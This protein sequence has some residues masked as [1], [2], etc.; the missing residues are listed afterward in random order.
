[1]PL[2]GFCPRIGHGPIPL[3]DLSG[4]G[5][6]VRLIGRNRNLSETFRHQ[7]PQG[8]PYPWPAEFVS[9]C[10]ES[11]TVLNGAFASLASLGEFSGQYQSTPQPQ[12]GL[13]TRHLIGYQD[14]DRLTYTRKNSEGGCDMARTGSL[15]IMGNYEPDFSDRE[16]TEEFASQSLNGSMPKRGVAKDSEGVFVSFVWVL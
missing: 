2:L 8:I 12:K 5:R 9:I 16:L 11:C 7:N 15:A 6:W 13:C 1:M 14:G 3:S 10:P 4:E